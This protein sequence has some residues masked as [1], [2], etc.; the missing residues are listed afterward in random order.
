MYVLDMYRFDDQNQNKTTSMKKLTLI[1]LQS[2]NPILKMK[3]M[4]SENEIV[5]C[6]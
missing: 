3:N 4:N 6:H 1:T 2:I 5:H